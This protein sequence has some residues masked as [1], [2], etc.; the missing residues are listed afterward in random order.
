M[1]DWY[2]LRSGGEEDGPGSGD[3]GTAADRYLQGGV[4]LRGEYITEFQS[5]VLLELPITFKGNTCTLFLN[6]QEFQSSVN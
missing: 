6:L 2:V 4:H 1:H 3:G 5:V